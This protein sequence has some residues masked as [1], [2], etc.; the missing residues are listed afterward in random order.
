MSSKIDMVP[1]LSVPSVP[2]SLHSI[3]PIPYDLNAAAL[4]TVTDNGFHP[5]FPPEVEAELNAL[6]PVNTPGAVDQRGLLWSSIDNDT[7][8]DLDQI[9]VA[10]QLFQ[11]V[12][13]TIRQVIKKD[14]LGLILD[15]AHSGLGGTVPSGSS[16][17][18]ATS[19]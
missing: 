12:E 17:M 1:Q 14:D 7:S 2:L 16:S 11:Q 13:D 3:V 8:R 15:M 10:E 19:L 6:V 5:Q 9:E 4:Q 18:V